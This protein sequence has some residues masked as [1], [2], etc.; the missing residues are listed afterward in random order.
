[1]TEESY[2]RFHVFCCTNRREAGHRRGCCAEKNAEVLREY[3]KRRVK[4]LGLPSVRVNMAGCLDRCE[5]GPVMV[6]YPQGVWYRCAN[7]EDVDRVIAE[8]LQ[9][10]RVVDALALAGRPEKS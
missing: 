4:E 10:G 5:E 7:K 8:H 9:Q 2:Y 3:M 6:I 1:M